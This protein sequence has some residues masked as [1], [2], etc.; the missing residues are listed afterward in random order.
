[1]QT[2]MD[3]RRGRKRP[4]THPQ[5]AGAPQA[6]PADPDVVRQAFTWTQLVLK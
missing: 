6:Q 3:V 5:Q 2:G 1:M 4:G